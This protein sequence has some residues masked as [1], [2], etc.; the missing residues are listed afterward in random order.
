[1]A[2]SDLLDTTKPDPRR[3]IFANHWLADSKPEILGGWISR[4][5]QR[6]VSAFWAAL[7]SQES[8]G[9][10]EIELKSASERLKLSLTNSLADPELARGLT[11]GSTE[12]SSYL[13]THLATILPPVKIPVFEPGALS[14]RASAMALLAALGALAGGLLGNGLFS[15]MGQ[16]AYTGFFPGVCLGAAISAWLGVT[17]ARNNQLRLRLLAI[18]GGIAVFDTIITSLKSAL[19]PSF[20]KGS[21][22]AFKRRIVYILAILALLMMKPET[23][24]DREKWRKLLESTALAWLESAAR[25]AAVLMFRLRQPSAPK[26]LPS[27]TRLTAEISVLVKRLMADPRLSDSLPLAEL[28]QKLGNAGYELTPEPRQVAPKVLAW[29]A[30]M[31][32]SYDTFGLVREGQS[33]IVEEEPIIRD[34]EVL[35]KGLVCP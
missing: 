10:T 33:V 7:P 11:G 21:N 25:V 30:I 26:S 13:A 35:K 24:L 1:L 12:D 8:S 14:P 32:K 34:G 31:A 16:P 17:L 3:D 2:G 9:P 4:S 5:A 22:M 20:L 15:L 23:S 6:A 19:I 28:A 18:V 29:Q 27:D